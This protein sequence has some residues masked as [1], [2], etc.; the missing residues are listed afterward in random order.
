MIYKIN[1]KN[2]SNLTLFSKT[3]SVALDTNVLLWN[4]Y[5][6]ITYSSEYQKDIYQLL[7]SKI[8][9]IKGCK[10]YTTTINIFEVFNVIE[11][12]EYKLYLND[13]KLDAQSFT[14]KQYRQIS[15]EREKIK[16]M[17]DL[18]LKQISECM[19]IIETSIHTDDIIEFNEHFTTHKYDI[20]DFS[21]LKFTKENNIDYLLT[22]D[23]DF[24]TGSYLI[25]QI[26][27]MTANRNLN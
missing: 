19:E 12:T 11:K 4:F 25:D 16:N 5:G 13:N 17:C 26:N 8:I 27:I 21:L 1:D 18:I 2:I 7:F 20:F 6:N 3:T 10:I 23:K 9:D 15:E 22:D 14:L 24:S